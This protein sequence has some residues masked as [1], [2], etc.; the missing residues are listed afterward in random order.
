MHFKCHD[1][2][3][4]T[5]SLGHRA[6]PLA[7]TV[8]VS[9]FTHTHSSP[10]PGLPE[11]II[12]TQTFLTLTTAGFLPDRPGGGVRTCVYVLVYCRCPSGIWTFPERRACFVLSH[13]GAWAIA[14]GRSSLSD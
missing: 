3:P 4:D 9:L 2:Y 12:V 13:P 10:L 5:L 1:S 8:K 14:L 11:A 6:P 7:S